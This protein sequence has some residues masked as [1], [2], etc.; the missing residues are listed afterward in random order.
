MLATL[1]G[2]ELPSMGFA[3]YLVF[4][5]H[6]GNLVKVLYN[7]SP[8]KGVRLADLK[9]R[10]LP[11]QAQKITQWSDLMVGSTSLADLEKHC[12][13]PA[14]EYWRCRIVFESPPAQ[15]KMR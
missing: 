7:E 10:V 6:E 13:L 4:E 5:L 12:I 14:Y 2:V 11:L 9:P 1:L 8:S 15:A 3:A